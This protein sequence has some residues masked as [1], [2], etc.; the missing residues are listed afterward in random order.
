MSILSIST[1]SP[2]PT[3]WKVKLSTWL[4]TF[5][6]VPLALFATFIHHKILGDDKSCG[7]LSSGGTE[8]IM[9][10]MLAY[11][12]QGKVRGIFEPEM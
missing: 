5:T 10:A 12:E 11:R 1:C 4:K 9:I 3:K 8:S 6:T 7:I 2:L